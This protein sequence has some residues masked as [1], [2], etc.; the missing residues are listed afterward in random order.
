[1]IVVR[2][3]QR[4]LQESGFSVCIPKSGTES[5]A[6]VTP[7]EP[8][9]VTAEVTPMTSGNNGAE[10]GAGGRDVDSEAVN[11]VMEYVEGVDDSVAH[12]VEIPSSPRKKRTM[13][14]VA[15]GVNTTKVL[16]MP[17]VPKGGTAD[18]AAAAQK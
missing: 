17:E 6:R 4:D 18:A 2:R 3:E 14:N 11:E 9:E 16:A 12:E 7:Q 1:M 10:P 8:T 5:G 13:T 15:V